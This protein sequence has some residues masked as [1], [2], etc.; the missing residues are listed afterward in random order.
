M[1]LDFDF[2]V[3]YAIRDAFASGKADDLMRA[4][5]MLGDGG[6]I[7][8]LLGVALLLYR[9][10]R[11]TGFAVLLALALTAVV[12]NLGLKPWS[13]ACVPATLWALRCYPFAHLILRFRLGTQLP[14]LRARACFGYVVRLGSGR[15]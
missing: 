8:I 5:T 6:F 13:I 12:G 10:T 15:L 11:W 2:S 1:T 9:R 3:L 7:W 14:P 4:I